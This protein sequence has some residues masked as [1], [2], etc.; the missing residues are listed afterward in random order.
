M[1][2]ARSSSSPD[3]DAR[4]K[5]EETHWPWW[6]PAAI[7]A[8]EERVRADLYRYTPLPPEMCEMIWSY[9]S[10]VL[11]QGSLIDVRGMY[12]RRGSHFRLHGYCAGDD[13]HAARYGVP[14]R[15]G[16]DIPNVPSS[17]IFAGF[18]HMV[19]MH[20]SDKEADDD[21]ETAYSSRWE[22]CEVLLVRGHHILVR[23]AIRKYPWPWECQLCAKETMQSWIDLE[24][25]AP[26]Q[27]A[28]ERTRSMRYITPMNAQRFDL[29]LFQHRVVEIERAE[30]LLLQVVCLDDFRSVEHKESL[31]YVLMRSDPRLCSLTHWPL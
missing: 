19:A 13:L 7:N 5:D 12:P 24:A 23:T 27:L 15:C 17:F 22:L 30:D 6:P 25:P 16:A 11:V 31:R 14:V 1:G 4:L 3:P 21:D 20:S 28:P 10:P 18:R 8:C 29:L 2:C 9:A 26:S